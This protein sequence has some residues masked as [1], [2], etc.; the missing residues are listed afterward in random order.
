MKFSQ[1]DCPDKNRTHSVTFDSD[2]QY[3]K[4]EPHPICVSSPRCCQLLYWSLRRLG[5]SILSWLP[6]RSIR[7]LSLF[8]QFLEVRKMRHLFQV[9]VPPWGWYSSDPWAGWPPISRHCQDT[10][11]RKENELASNR[12]RY[13]L[14]SSSSEYAFAIQTGYS[15]ESVSKSPGYR[16]YGLRLQLDS[17]ELHDFHLKVVSESW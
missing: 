2:D 4:G 8:C 16:G 14:Y 10:H 6:G 9:W 13:L 1:Q 17:L 15:I 12:Q 7:T 11:T 3:G 5:P